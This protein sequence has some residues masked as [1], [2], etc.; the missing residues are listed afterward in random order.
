MLQAPLPDGLLLD[1]L[2]RFLDLRAAAMMDAGGLPIRADTEPSLH[3]LR[4]GITR[5]FAT[6]LRG[7]TPAVNL[8]IPCVNP[9]L[10]RTADTPPLVG[11][12]IDEQTSG[13]GD[14]RTNSERAAE[15]RIT[16]RAG[17]VQVST[18]E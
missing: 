6:P 15:G 10:T 1:L 14:T 4:V 5:S 18:S 16:V 3:L 11:A 8:T 2:S 12:A 7:G 9:P 13:I 17:R